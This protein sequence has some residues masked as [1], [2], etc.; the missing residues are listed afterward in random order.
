MIGRNTHF[1]IGVHVLTALAVHD[2]PVPS[3]GL[4]ESVGTNAAFLRQLIGELRDAGLVETKLGKGGGALLARP[5]DAITLLDVY[6][7]TQ[8]DPGLRT[9]C[10]N[11]TSE[12][13]IARGIPAV[14]KEL[15]G[16][17]EN[18]LEQE[19]SLTTIAQVV[20]RVSAEV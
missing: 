20:T 6:N 3:S 8:E 1:S 12:C 4:A 19:L 9:H 15:S 14:L 10:C 5:A 18:A 7:A 16:R 17:L 2:D 13:Y 11:P